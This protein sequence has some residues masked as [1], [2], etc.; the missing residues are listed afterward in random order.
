MKILLDT[1]VWLWL[2]LEPSRLPPSFANAIGAPENEIMVSVASI[3][4]V[5]I[6][7]RLGKL[8]VPGPFQAFV[9]DALREIQ[10]LGIDRFHVER[11][12]TLPL[13]RVDV[14]PCG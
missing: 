13:L 10:V 7:H 6:K 14:S 11:L 9:D 5:S 4:E 8:D 1:H 12:H 3:W 2:N